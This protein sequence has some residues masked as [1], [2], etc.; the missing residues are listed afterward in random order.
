M[1]LKTDADLGAFLES[2]QSCENDVFFDT[3]EGDHLN[4]KSTLAAF[5]FSAAAEKLHK[6]DYR[7]IA[8]PEDQERLRAYW[9]DEA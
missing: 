1:R 5:V 3:A 8:A 6:L 2:V 9:E 7:I 4:L